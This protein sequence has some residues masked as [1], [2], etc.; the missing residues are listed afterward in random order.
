MPRLGNSQPDRISQTANYES[1]PLDFNAEI[2]LLNKRLIEFA[3][4]T[5]TL[6]VSSGLGLDESARQR[7]A[8]LHE[9]LM[10]HYFI[11]SVLN[12]ETVNEVELS[13][14]QLNVLLEKWRLQGVAVGESL[15][16]LESSEDTSERLKDS[17]RQLIEDLGIIVEQADSAATEIIN[18]KANRLFIMTVFALSVASFILGESTQRAVQ[19]QYEQGSMEIWNFLVNTFGSNLAKFIIGQMSDLGG[20][21]L[22]VTSHLMFG[23]L[24]QKNKKISNLDVSEFARRTSYYGIFFTVISL[25]MDVRNDT[26]I[27]L[28]DPLIFIVPVITSLLWHKLREIRSEAETTEQSADEW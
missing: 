3:L 8:Q 13:E 20:P 17:F 27:D 7:L 21:F 26:H 22:M 9:S 14:D 16:K 19:F 18:S 1:E 25:I 23:E 5:R 2:E 28:A 24:I 15:V 12:K 11:S 4:S 6:L 10:K